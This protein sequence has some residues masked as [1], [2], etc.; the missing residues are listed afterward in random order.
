MAKKKK[1]AYSPRKIKTGLLAAPLD[2]WDSY[3]DYIRIEV[4][5]KDIISLTK[6]YVKENYDKKQQKELLSASENIFANQRGA[7]ATIF[8]DKAGLEFP[9]KWSKTRALEILVENLRENA[10]TKKSNKVVVQKK[11]PMTLLQN[12]ISDRLAELDCV[13]DHWKDNSEFDMYNDLISNDESYKLAKSVFDEYSPLV[14]EL[15]ELINNKPDDL[16]EAY[17]YLKPREKKNYRDFIAKIVADAEKYM[18]NKQAKRKPRI[19]KNKTADKQ[20]VKLNYLMESKEHQITSISPVSIIG[21]SRLYTFNTKYRKLTEYVTHGPKGF[22]MKGSTLQ[23]WDE[24]VSR[25]TKL[26][27]PEDMLRL[28][29]S[30]TIRSIDKAWKQLTT[31]TNKTTGRIN[32]DTILIKVIR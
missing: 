24:D 19:T 4:D 8:W 11:S 14:T 26:R 9:A 22:E 1:K 10:A 3:F 16:V 27:H 17:H 7:A 12:R 25:E 15:V 32:K 6:T 5:Q 21:A 2:N 18:L 31:K 20:I 28:V 29:Q 13:I 30:G 23:M